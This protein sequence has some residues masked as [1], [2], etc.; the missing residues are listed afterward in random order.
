MLSSAASFLLALQMTQVRA[1][2]DGPVRASAVQTRIEASVAR[3]ENGNGLG[4][5]IG[6]D[7]V[8]LSD[9]YLVT[10]SPTL[11]FGQGPGFS[12]VV[13]GRDRVTRL[14]VVRLPAAATA[15]R[16]PIGV[17]RGLRAGDVVTAATLGGAVRGQSG[18]EELVGLSLPSRR[19]LPMS[20]FAFERSVTPSGSG[21][22]FDEDGRLVG[23]L[24]AALSSPEPTRFGNYGPT[25]MQV[26]YSVAPRVLERVVT[27]F[28]RPPFQIQYPTIG[29]NFRNATGSGAEITAVEPGSA[30]EKGGLQAG[31]VVLAL[32]GRRMDSAVD[33]AAG[34]FELEIGQQVRL[35]VSRGRD[36]TTLT[37]TVDADR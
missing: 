12:G 36:R 21:P 30:A 11:A 10:N 26:A 31:D 15:G 25:G 1:A 19:F 8:L 5:L 3:L 24:T 17:G 4:V 37:L 20:E 9:D 27:S 7:L 29:A 14:A 2:Q 13:V 22:V 18:R 33:F 32:N 16:T 34:L 23:F 28:T 6:P 35:D